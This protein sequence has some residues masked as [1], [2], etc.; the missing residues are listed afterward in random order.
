MARSWLNGLELATAS[1]PGTCV[2]EYSVNWRIQKQH[3]HCESEEKEVS[4]AHPYRYIAPI[5]FTDIVLRVNHPNTSRFN[6][7]NGLPP[8]TFRLPTLGPRQATYSVAC[9]LLPR[10][11]RIIRAGVPSSGEISAV[12]MRSGR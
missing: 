10:A 2:S 4:G 1:M 7:E 8:L 12:P 9:P 5:R 6:A 11:I 3:R